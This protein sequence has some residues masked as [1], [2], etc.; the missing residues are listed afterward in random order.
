MSK[1]SLF[2]ALILFLSTGIQGTA[3]QSFIEV[4]GNNFK[5]RFQAAITE[6]RAGS[7]PTRFW[8]AY[9][10][11]PRAGYAYRAEGKNGGSF[12]GR[13]TADSAKETRETGNVA[14][15]SLLE[16][17]G[18]TVEVALRNLDRNNDQGKLPVYWLGHADNK[19]SLNYL[20]GL[21]EANP[22]NKASDSAVQAV[23]L[24]D[25]PLAAEVLMGLIRNSSAAN[26]KLKAVQWLSM[27]SEARPFFLELVRNEHESV[28]LRRQ[29]VFALGVWGQKTPALADLEVVYKVI[30]NREVKERI[31]LVAQM[32]QS[33]NAERFLS[34]VATTDVNALTRKRAILYLGQKPGSRSFN[35]LSEAL[36][37]AEGD[38]EVQRTVL[39]AISQ[40][41][42]DE[43]IP[44]L[45]DVA[46]KHSNKQLRNQAVFW[47]QRSDDERAREFLKQSN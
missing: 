5:D 30:T 43:A 45:I 2:L 41:P 33:E 12:S 4:K 25:G 8:I 34:E 46:E 26:V 39:M 6:A 23:A 16:P 37:R 38:F 42:R 24:H 1:Y 28:D 19:D 21:L 29:A 9:S 15:F 13:V 3:Q 40:R 17:N 18:T 36:N 47:L 44:F 27:I 7:K 35:A 14:V 31:L 10:F 20:Q 32:D 11:N 22:A